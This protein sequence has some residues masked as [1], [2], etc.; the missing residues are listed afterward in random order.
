MSK[1]NIKHKAP[2]QRFFKS[3]FWSFISSS[4]VLALLSLPFL[5]SVY[6]IYYAIRSDQQFIPFSMF[7]LIAGLIYESYRI[8]K[9]Y[10]QILIYSLISYVISLLAFLPDKNEIS[11]SFDTHFKIWIFF[12]LFTYLLIFIFQHDKKPQLQLAKAP[13]FYFIWLSSIGCMNIIY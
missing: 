8:T 5:F 7:A 6:L 1:K 13:V 3:S 12:Y 4:G 10:E 11:Y 2:S 9:S